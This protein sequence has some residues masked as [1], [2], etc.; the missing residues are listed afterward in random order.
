MTIST[1]PTTDSLRAR[2]TTIEPLGDQIDFSCTLEASDTARS[3]DNHRLKIRLPA[4]SDLTLGES[5]SIT[6]DPSR[7][8]LFEPG[9]FGQRL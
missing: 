3:P 9:E 8:C 2:I 7:V 1:E 5:I 4:R 6:P